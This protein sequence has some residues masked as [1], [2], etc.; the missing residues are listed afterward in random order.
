MLQVMLVL[1]VI[2]IRDAGVIRFD[3]PLHQPDD[4]CRQQRR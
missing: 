1:L 2:G 3:L 4:L